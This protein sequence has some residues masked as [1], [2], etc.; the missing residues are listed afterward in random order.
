VV[1]K[2]GVEETKGEEVVD[3]LFVVDFSQEDSRGKGI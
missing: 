3:F 1:K 2:A